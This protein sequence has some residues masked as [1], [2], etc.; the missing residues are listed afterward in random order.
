M[1]TAR[2]KSLASVQAVTPAAARSQA[3]PVPALA[4]ERK[5]EP[6]LVPQHRESEGPSRTGLLPQQVFVRTLSRERSRTERSRKPF[7]LMLLNVAGLGKNGAKAHAL[8]RLM[9]TLVKATRDTDTLGWFEDQ[10]TIGIIFTEFGDASMQSVPEALV[11]RLIAGM[12]RRLNAE[13]VAKIEITCHVYPEQTPRQKPP[14]P[15]NPSLYPDLEQRDRKDWLAKLV[16][17]SMDITVSATILLLLA[18]VLLVIAILVKLTSPGPVFFRQKRIGQYGVPFTFLKFRSMQAAGDPKIHR[19][20]V[21]RFIRGNAE[22]NAAGEKKVFKLTN[23]PRV[24]TIGRVIRRTSLD[25]LP[26]LFN[27][28][29]G[30]M[31]LVGPRPPIDYELEVY[32]IW[33]RRRLLEAKPG[34]TGLWQ[35]SGRSKTSFDDMVRLDLQY[36][37]RYS[38]WLDL[39]I[40]IKTPA[41]VVSGEG[42]H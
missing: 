13:E 34:I 16:K 26:Q 29:R 24:T 30:E 18:P 15:T 33:H 31:S 20:Y 42:A 19:D 21:V 39:K 37:R 7:V 5:P 14:A 17:R 40:L 28:L 10:T 32:D 27:V 23:D 35:I 6:R 11:T 9:P 25:E 3:I 36:A 22:A 41:A 2:D 1:K 12:G 8:R 4:A 38:L